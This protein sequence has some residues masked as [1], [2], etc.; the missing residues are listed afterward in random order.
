[1]Q[2]VA[3]PMKDLEVPVHHRHISEHFTNAP[4]FVIFDAEGKVV[5]EVAV[6]ETGDDYVATLKDNGVEIVICDG[7]TQAAADA[8]Q[9]AGIEVWTC[10]SGKP[11]G[12]I[13]KFGTGELLHI[14]AT[15]RVVDSE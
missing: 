8:I 3:L 11:E 9:D 1:M 15:S 2:R 6:V 14:L 7:I 12:A 4:G 5:R 10:I 13:A